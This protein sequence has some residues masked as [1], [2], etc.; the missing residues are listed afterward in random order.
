LEL[1]KA[2]KLPPKGKD[3]LKLE[4]SVGWQKTPKRK[5]RN[6]DFKLQ[7]EGSELGDDSCTEFNEE[8][9]AWEMRE[10]FIDS[11][12]WGTSASKT[13]RI[14]KLSIRDKSA[15]EIMKGD[16]SKSDLSP[17]L[18]YTPNS[19]ISIFESKSSASK[20]TWD[21][22]WNKPIAFF[23]QQINSSK[24]CCVIKPRRSKLT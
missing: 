11:I 7:F 18:G 6:N 20:L 22:K 24:E 13:Q 14:W 16:L 1:F 23:N 5:K 4:W 19:T 10:A 21:K 3:L 17:R 15:K 12:I 2:K 8:E 9:Y